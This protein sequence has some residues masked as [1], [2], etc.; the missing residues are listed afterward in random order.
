MKAKS[1]KTLTAY[2][3]EDDQLR[4]NLLAQKLK[5]SASEV[6]ILLVRGKY[7]DVFGENTPPQKT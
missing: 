2:G 7:L 5:K 6:L 3:T 4:L 1:T